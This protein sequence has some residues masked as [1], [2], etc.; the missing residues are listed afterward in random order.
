[1]STFCYIFNVIYPF[2]T[3]LALQI[4][5]EVSKSTADFG[6]TVSYFC[7]SHVILTLNMAALGR[8]FNVAKN[9]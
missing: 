6:Q 1:M 8:I 9:C 7:D 5:S 4:Q 2:E 3:S